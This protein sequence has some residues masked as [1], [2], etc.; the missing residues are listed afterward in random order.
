MIRVVKEYLV[1][2]HGENGNGGDRA[3]MVDDNNNEN[4]LIIRE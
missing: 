4:G 2:H 1:K 3:I